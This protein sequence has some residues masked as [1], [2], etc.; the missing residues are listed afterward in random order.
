MNV[1]H[2]EVGC[3]VVKSSIA[4]LVKDLNSAMHEATTCP[5]SCSE[6]QEH[7]MPL[8]LLE[9]LDMIGSMFA[10]HKDGEYRNNSFYSAPCTEWV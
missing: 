6:A 7:P 10:A 9:L 5:P 3:K 2:V 1:G 8:D 4:S